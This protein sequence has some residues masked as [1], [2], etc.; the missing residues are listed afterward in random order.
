MSQ[1]VEPRVAEAAPA[2]PLLTGTLA[3][4]VGC[5]LLASLLM[6]LL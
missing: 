4:V 1:P 3:L 2:R 5:C 6:S